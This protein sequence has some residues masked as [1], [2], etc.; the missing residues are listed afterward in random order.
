MNPLEQRLK[1]LE[2]WKEQ[3]M[4]QQI[5]YPL[6]NQS[7]IILNKYY[8]SVIANIFNL[9]ASGEEFRKIITQ[10]D[11][12]LYVISALTQFMTYTA[13]AGSDVL[14][15]GADLSTG[16]QGVLS[17][18][19]FVTINVP[20][21]G[22]APGGLENGHGYFVVNT[23]STTVQLSGTKGGSAINITSSGTGTQYIASTD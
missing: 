21:P 18:D 3:R 14:T 6:D 16:Q 20:T 12:K 2:D 11:G 8:L 23:T 1:V 7:Q 13:N 22:T 4:R 5:T 10:Q 9:S 15:L 19:Q 17:N